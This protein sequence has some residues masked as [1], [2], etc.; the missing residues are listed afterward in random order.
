[1]IKLH[2]LKSKEEEQLEYLYPSLTNVYGLDVRFRY[3]E[4][5]MKEEKD[6]RCLKSKHDAAD[7]DFLQKMFYYNGDPQK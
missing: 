3:I 2:A 7:P 5:L 6:R 1:M 4:K